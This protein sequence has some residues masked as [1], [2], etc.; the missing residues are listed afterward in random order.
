MTGDRIRASVVT[1]AD[2]YVYLASCAGQQLQMPPSQRGVRTKAGDPVLV[3]EGGGELVLDSDPG[4]EVLYLILS[5]NELSLADPALAALIVATGDGAQAVDCG[6][7]LD[8]RLMKTTGGLPPSNVL[9]G[10]RIP[11][12]RM[13][14][15]RTDSAE[16]PDLVANP[17]DI[18]WYAADG[19]R[20]PGAVVAADVDGIAIVRY[21]FIHVTPEHD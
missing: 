3:P 5:R 9:R 14:R 4:S 6:S 17:G 12:K 11:K 18:V 7:S 2:A 19:V 1:S 8:I 16:A 21:R 15:S 10:E 13:P 20:S